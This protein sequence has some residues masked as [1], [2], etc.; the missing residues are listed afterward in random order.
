M[1]KIYTLENDSLK[2]S[3]SSL[4][5]TIL[6]F[7]DKNENVDIALGFKNIDEYPNNSVYFGAMIGRNANRI[8]NAQFELNGVTYQIEKNDGPNNLHS[9]KDTFAFKEFEE[10]YVDK[11]KLVL[12]YI[13]KD[14]ES[15][16]PG[17]LTFICI[18]EL[19]DNTLTINFSGTSDQDTIFGITNHSYFNLGEE[20]ILNHELQVKTN[21]LCLND[22]NGM[23]TDDVIDVKGTS[24][25]FVDYKKIGDNFALKH[26]N[27]A[28]GG[29]DHNYVFED[30]NFKEM[31][32]LRNGKYELTVSS[33]LPDVQI[34]TGNYFDDVNG[35]Q[36]YKQYG[37][38]A[39]E[40]QFAPNAI[41][42]DKFIKPIL[43]KNDTKAYKIEYKL[44]RL[45]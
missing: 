5:G 13:S 29:I 20:N 12:K 26:E 33:D 14:K 10:D 8:G 9:G 42:Y 40:P 41:N 27:L 45:G 11:N 1:T 38:V 18:Y 19:K 36:L 6:S 24:F 35:K 17:N 22:S 16:F 15:G 23:A 43:L 25:D 30:M 31:V 4:G 2:I 37:G 21:K 34:Y 7:I 28:K 3:V 44:E 39:I 32:K